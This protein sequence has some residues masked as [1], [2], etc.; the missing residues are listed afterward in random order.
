M[1]LLSPGWSSYAAVLL[2]FPL[3]SIWSVD[4]LV[5]LKHKIVFSTLIA[6]YA[7]VPVAIF[8]DLP[9]LFKFPKVFLLLA[10]FF[11]YHHLLKN[12]D[13]KF[14]FSSMMLASSLFIVFTVIGMLS[15]NKQSNLYAINKEEHILTPKLFTPYVGKDLPIRLPQQER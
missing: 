5:S 15:D 10:I 8:L 9:L 1:M 7:N 11:Y 2:L 3:F 14:R 6:F 12:S 4:S 13:K